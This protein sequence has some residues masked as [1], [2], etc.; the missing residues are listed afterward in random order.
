M[1]NLS[2][3]ALEENFITKFGSYFYPEYYKVFISIIPEEER[4]DILKAYHKRIHSKDKEI[5]IKY[6]RAWY[7]WESCLCSINFNPD[8][9]AAIDRGEKDEQTLKLSKIETH[10]FI[11][12]AFFEVSS[13]EL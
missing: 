2:L 3:R 4:S 1:L 12:K 13:Q 6:S 9:L 5:S 7:K 11:N 10:Y 8:D